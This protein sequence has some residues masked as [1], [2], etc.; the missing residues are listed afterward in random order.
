M[1]SVRQSGDKMA[2][3]ASTLALRLANL[4]TSTGKNAV[5]F[6]T[7]RLNT[8]W[9]YAKVELR[10]PTLGELGQVQEGLQKVVNSARSGKFQNLTVKD[11]WLNSLIAA[12]IV[13]CFCIG[14]VLGRGSL[15]GYYIPGAV[16]YVAEI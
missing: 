15:V 13:F 2:K 16:H 12:E 1:G 11:A 5:K 10:P 3:A 8:F 4:A 6:T 7:P 14:E 9:G